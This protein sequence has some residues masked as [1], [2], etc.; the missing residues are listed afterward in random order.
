MVQLTYLDLT[1]NQISDIGVVDLLGLLKLTHLYLMSNR[2]TLKSVLNLFELS[3][4]IVFDVRFNLNNALD[5][6]TARSNK[7]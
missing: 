2:I 6:E 4:L 3:K 1:N 7:P 5:K